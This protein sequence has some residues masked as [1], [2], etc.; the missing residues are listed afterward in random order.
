[1]QLPP[2]ELAAGRSRG[3]GHS[4]HGRYTLA[5]PPVGSLPPVCPSH[6]RHARHATHA[7][8]AGYATGAIVPQQLALAF[9]ALPPPLSAP[10]LSAGLLAGGSSTETAVLGTLAVFSLAGVPTVCL[11]DVL[12][13][14]GSPLECSLQSPQSPQYF[15]T[16][17]YLLCGPTRDC[18]P[19]VP[20][21]SV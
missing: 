4:P 12:A 20:H 18:L 21:P 15:S 13:A 10:A 1:M 19:T 7:R 2:G 6:T 5:G 8:D 9:R 11:L 3:R 16:H 17:T 14:G